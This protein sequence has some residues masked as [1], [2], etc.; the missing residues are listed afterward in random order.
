[1]KKKLTYEYSNI[2]IGYCNFSIKLNVDIETKEEL[3]DYLKDQIG[4]CSI[5]NVNYHKNGASF[6]FFN[7]EDRM[8]FNLC[9]I[10]DHPVIQ[11]SE[12]F[13]IFKKYAIGPWEK[14][15]KSRYIDKDMYTK[16]EAQRISQEIFE[17][18]RD[19]LKDKD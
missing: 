16:E 11:E 10:K 12:P 18:F 6:E 4:S 3:F 8:L 2:L 1:M 17:A 5:Y 13:K 19:T 14:N 9:G 7:K 15:I